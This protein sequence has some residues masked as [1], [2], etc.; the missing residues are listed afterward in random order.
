MIVGSST[1]LA[2]ETMG[3]STASVERDGRVEVVDDAEAYLGLTADGIEEGGPLFD[4]A[5]RRPPATFDVV[6]QLSEPIAVTLTVDEFRFGSADGADVSDDR[7]VV[8]QTESDRLGPGERIEDVTVELDSQDAESTDETVSGTL[9]IE[10]DGDDTRIEAERGLTLERPEITV[11]T[12]ALDMYPIGGYLFE[13][14]WVLHGVE[15]DSVALERFRFDYG[16]I[17]TYTPLDFTDRDGPSVSITV[18]G[19][20]HAGS[21]DRETATTLDVAL[22]SPVEID[23]APVVITL[24]DTGPPASPGGGHESPSGATIELVGDGVST[25]VEATWRRS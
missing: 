7:L 21:I 3:F 19:T 20:D 8:G 25:R 6:N 4:G 24:T 9:G 17:R 2:A 18:D 16:D 1:V 5:P 14:E 12:A 11:D 10:A 22:E 15:T 23:D 13:H